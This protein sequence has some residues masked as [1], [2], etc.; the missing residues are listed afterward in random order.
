V[1]Q[2]R[3]TLL[4]RMSGLDHLADKTFQT[5][6]PEGVGL[7]ERDRMNLRAAYEHALAFA[8]RPQGWL[9]LIGGYGCGKTHLAAAIANARIEAGDRALFLTVPDL[10]DYLRAAYG[11]DT[12]G[13]GSYQARFEEVRTTP[14]LVLDDLGTESPTAWALEKL[15][16]ILNHRYNAHLP[17][18]ITTNHALEEFDLRLRSR[19]ADPDN[20][21]VIGI[22]APDYRRSGAPIGGSSLN[23]LGLYRDKTFETFELELDLPAK[24]AENLRRAYE[25]ARA[26]AETSFAEHLDMAPLVGDRQP[27][28]SSQALPWLILTGL[29][30]CGKTHLAAAIAN[31]QVTHNMDVMFVKVSD[32]LDHLRA[33]YGPNSTV[34]H[35]ERFREVKEAPLLVLDD[36]GVEASTP[37][38]SAKLYQLFD[39]RYITRRP[40]VVTTTYRFD[41]LEEAIDPRLATRMRDSRLCRIFAILAPAYVGRRQGRRPRPLST[42]S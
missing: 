4:R 3:K 5:F 26:Y 11:P 30:G 27:V 38:A 34:S 22:T 21:R 41:M 12:E 37:W 10:L 13:V 18:V 20:S 36:L 8:E 19:L 39:Y 40:T 1:N 6:N 7:I 32:L 42:R 2:E 24:E 31:V 35:D 9:V 33:T 25:V 23:S 14:L 15:Y 17:T 16:Q 29:S 28:S